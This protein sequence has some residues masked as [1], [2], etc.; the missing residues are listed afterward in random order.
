MADLAT[1]EDVAV[2]L[3]R[4]ADP[5]DVKMVENLAAASSL[6]RIAIGQRLTFVADEKIAL[7]GSG[8]PELLL[9][10]RPVVEVATVSIVDDRDVETAVT[11]YR[12]G[13][14]DAQL[15]RL[16]D[17]VWPVGFLNVR[18]TYS[19]GYSLPG[20]TIT[21]PPASIDQMPPAIRDYVAS[22]AA[23]LYQLVDGR[24][25]IAETLGGYSYQVAAEGAGV[26]TSGEIIAAL[27]TFR[28]VDL[29]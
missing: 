10:Q 12:V 16:N 27:S 20:E 24:P 14:S 28:A 13:Y 11:D 21:D 15:F 6:V 9:P 22:L 8:R 25:V 19:H 26:P 3:G 17:D 1:L 5:S 18:I 7:S 4:A 29:A 2:R 23:R